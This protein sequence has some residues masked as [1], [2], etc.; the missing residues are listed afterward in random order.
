MAISRRGAGRAALRRAR[1]A[2]RETARSRD[3]CQT[4]PVADRG[5]GLRRDGVSVRRPES[6]RQSGVLFGLSSSQHHTFCVQRFDRLRGTRRLYAS[7]MTLLGH[8]DG[9]SGSYL[10]IDQAI[11][12]PED[13][14]FKARCLKC[15]FPVAGPCVWIALLLVSPTFPVPGAPRPVCDGNDIQRLA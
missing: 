6:P 15:L 7:T 13:R 2:L 11:E 1:G 14:A 8:Q 9:D 12:Q 10:E 5:V 3:I 4:L